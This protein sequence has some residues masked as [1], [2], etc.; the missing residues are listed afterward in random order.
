L[1]TVQ[2]E[3]TRS[4]GYTV[5]REYSKHESQNLAFRDRADE[6]RERLVQD[7]RERDRALNANGE[8]PLPEASTEN[9]GASDYLDPSKII[10]IH[11][12]SQNLRIGFASDAL[13]KTITMCLGTKFPNTESEEFEA[14]P[15]RQFELPKVEQQHGEEWSKHYK[16]QCE[17]LKVEMRRDRRKVLPNSKDLVI[18]FNRRT[19]PEV[20]PQHNDPLQVEWTDIETLPD[21]NTNTGVFYGHKALRIPDDSD[22]KFRVWWPM[23]HGWLNED[24]YTTAEH[25]RDDFQEVFTRA[26]KDELGLDIARCKSYR[27]VFVIPDLYDRNYVHLALEDCLKWFEFNSVSFIQ[28]GFAATCGAGFSQSCVVDVG[29]QKTAI[30]CVEDGL[31]IED[32]RINLKYG[33]YDVTETFIKMMLFDHFPYQDINLRRRYDFLLAEELKIKY[34]NYQPDISVQT[35]NFHLRAPNQDTL[36]YQFKV[37]DE[38]ILAPMGFYDPSIFDNSSKLSGRHKLIKRSYNAYDPD[39]PDDPVSAA[40]TA[41]LALIKPSVTSNANGFVPGA[42]ND[43]ST[44]S[45]EKSQP[46]N[47]LGRGET[48]GTPMASHAGSPAPEGAN[49]PVPAPFVFGRDANGAASPAPS[50]RNGGTP[51]PNGLQLPPGQVNLP[52]PGMF[53][54]QFHRTATDIAEERD[55]VLPV[56]ALDIAIMTSIQNAAKGDERKLREYLGSIMVIGGGSKT[57]GFGAYLEERLK[58]RRPD[59]AERIL[60]SKSARDMD[61]QVVVW[62]GASVFAKLQ[63]NDSWI[64]RKEWEYHRERALHNKVL[65]HWS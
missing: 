20:I 9:L 34:C 42:S 35:Y 50:G 27:C 17:D 44:P 57:P 13:P 30:S 29:A 10:V 49:T 41:I 65:W 33:G 28:E 60:V 54:D 1:Q 3:P 2:L 45:K 46:F 21:K 18:N 16:K 56:A 38:V 7:T 23:Q 12:G 48:N 32:S 62:K 31:V 52:P 37:Y 8:L 4:E 47:F 19:E 24:A 22:P 11:P 55:S 39:L 15:R 63:T 58:A 61:E 36:K 25:L 51:A 64:T 5:I 14:R 6:A 59:L 53:V 40:Q 26:I 43:I